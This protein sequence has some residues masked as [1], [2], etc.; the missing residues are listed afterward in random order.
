MSQLSRH[1]K[2]KLSALKNIV[3]AKYCQQIASCPKYEGEFLK[4]HVAK[5]ML[6]IC[7]TLVSRLIRPTSFQID[8][9]RLPYLHETY[10][11]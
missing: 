10:W 9:N 2:V 7:S 4:G 3:S 1:F 5:L 6:Q 8:M 11:T